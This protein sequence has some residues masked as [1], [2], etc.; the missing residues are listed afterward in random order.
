MKT[1]QDMNF[2]PVVVQEQFFVVVV[3]ILMLSKRGKLRTVSILQSGFQ[4]S[5]VVGKGP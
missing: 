2:L 3:G 5:A 4:P 1:Q